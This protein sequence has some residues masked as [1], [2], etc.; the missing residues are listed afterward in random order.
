MLAE[1]Q[2]KQTPTEITSPTL[3]GTMQRSQVEALVAAVAPVL[4]LDGRRVLV[5]LRLIQT[6]RPQDWISSAHEPICAMRQI[7]LAALL[8]KTPR[9]LRSDERQFEALGLVRK[10]VANDGSRGATYGASG[11]AHRL[12]LSFAPLIE[13]IPDLLELR[14]LIERDERR[15][16]TARRTASVLRR[17]LRLLLERMAEDVP[18]CAE[19]V[20][21]EQFAA[22]LPRR[23]DHLATIEAIE[24]HSRQVETAVDKALSLVENQRQTSGA[25]EVHGRPLQE[26]PEEKS[27][28]CNGPAVD[29]RPARKRAETHS[30]AAPPAGAANCSENERAASVAPV[31]EN[32]IARF[33]L[34]AVAEA[35]SEEMRFYLDAFRS[36]PVTLPD[37]LRAAAMRVPE[38]GISDSAWADALDVMGPEVAAV[39]LLIVDANRAHPT[40]PVLNPGGLLRSMTARHRRGALNITGSLIGLLARTAR[41]DKGDTL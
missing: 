27:G 20:A 13:R 6:T 24:E 25:P 16:R 33:K 12:G 39:A 14:E 38:L 26:T 32:L 29:T 3:P 34:G 2:A 10:V 21:I 30:F 40:T 22:S 41:T 36:G 17:E 37:L 28:L 35:A 9:A 15:L 8:G 18:L 4:G 11:E 1:G 23:Y 19:R 5:L 31:N 7:D